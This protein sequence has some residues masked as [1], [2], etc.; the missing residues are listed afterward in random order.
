MKQE[1]KLINKRAL[2]KTRKEQNKN[3]IN[4]RAQQEMVGFVLIVILV[5]VIGF[6]FLTVFMTQKQTRTT[7]GI[8]NLLQAVMYYTS[9]C[10]SQNNEPRAVEDLINEC[11]KKPNKKCYAEPICSQDSATSLTD[12]SFSPISSKVSVDSKQG[13]W[14]HQSPNG[15]ADK[16]KLVLSGLKQ[17]YKITITG[18][19]GKI[20][21][22]A[23]YYPYVDCSNPINAG[24]Y[25]DDNKL[26]SQYSLANFKRG[27][28]IPK[29]ATK[30]YTYMLDVKNMYSDNTGT[31]SFTA[32]ETEFNGGKKTSCKE[33]PEIIGVCD[34]V[35][36][37][38]EKALD[39]SL[40]VGDLYKNKAYR[41]EV[42]YREMINENHLNNITSL[43]NGNFANCSSIEGGTHTITIGTS[44]SG[45][46][47]SADLLVCKNRGF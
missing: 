42:Y 35:E 11:N 10:Y 5:T 26:I 4:K 12:S 25:D 16:P 27:V 33:N 41:L 20:S 24:F 13:P 2:I 8:S 38:L 17:G 9:D 3:M 21:S 40:N 32:T 14:G 31:C 18:I 22:S 46:V 37:S 45:G 43:A 30:L 23:G 6:I 15:N 44:G 19:S 47:I 34:A 1:K 28:I 39:Q 7:A 29:G 36:A